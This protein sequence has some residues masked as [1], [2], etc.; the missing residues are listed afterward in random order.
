MDTLYANEDVNT[1]D[2]SEGAVKELFGQLRQASTYET[3]KALEAQLQPM[4]K[5]ALSPGTTCALW[6]IGRRQAATNGIKDLFVLK[7]EHFSLKR[8]LAHQR[9]L[10]I[11][12]HQDFEHCSRFIRDFP[13][14]RNPRKKNVSLYQKALDIVLHRLSSKNEILQTITPE[15]ARH[16]GIKNY[17]DHAK[18]P[19]TQAH[20]G[21][22]ECFIA[23][24]KA[25]A[26][27]LP[28][29][30]YEEIRIA[31]LKAYSKIFLQS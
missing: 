28:Q 20:I 15:V 10:E 7:K 11:I 8:G 3:L 23:G 17:P 1:L 6:L 2:C 30:D 27:G 16:T 22:V 31:G 21:P 13:L 18:N 24:A 14:V 19:D 25:S 9:V 29:N 5:G 12:A 4:S 26:N